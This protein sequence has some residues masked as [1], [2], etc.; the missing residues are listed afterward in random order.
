MSKFALIFPLLC[1]FSSLSKSRTNR[2][3]CVSMK[4]LDN[5]E[6]KINSCWRWSAY[7]LCTMT[8]I[9]RVLLIG[10]KIILVALVQLLS[11]LRQQ[12]IR[13]NPH[14]VEIQTVTSTGRNLCQ[15][16]CFIISVVEEC[17][18]RLLKAGFLELKEVDHWDI[19]PSNKV[20][21]WS[22]IVEIRQY[23]HTQ[24]FLDLSDSYTFYLVPFTFSK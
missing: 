1:Y 2:F 12:V 8:R 13:H 9:H 22:W 6:L 14:T 18:Q 23:L 7:Y 4:N 15:P 21:Q 5:L 10:S 20:G 17:R 19:Q 11:A 3:A 16:F 24:L